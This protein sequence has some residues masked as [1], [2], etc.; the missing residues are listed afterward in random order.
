M[1]K[2]KDSLHDYNKLIIYSLATVCTVH[3]LTL[4]D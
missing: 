4:I 3:A 2:I 1:S